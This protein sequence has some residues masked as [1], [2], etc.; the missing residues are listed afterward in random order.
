MGQHPG[1]PMGMTYIY[2]ADTF[3]L[4][5]LPPSWKTIEYNAVVGGAMM[6]IQSLAVAAA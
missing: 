1:K 4:P 5:P 6:A 3:A 2:I